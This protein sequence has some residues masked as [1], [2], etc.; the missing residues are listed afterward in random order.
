MPTIIWLH[1]FVSVGRVSTSVSNCHRCANARLLP[2]CHLADSLSASSNV[3]A[4]T[5]P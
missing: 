5:E 2:R 3:S 4:H 1:P